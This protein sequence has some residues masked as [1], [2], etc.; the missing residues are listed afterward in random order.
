M[1]SI[2]IKIIL[3]CISAQ[4]INSSYAND[5]KSCKIYEH[6]DQK[7]HAV[8][9]NNFASLNNFDNYFIQRRSWHGHLFGWRG[10]DI[11][12]DKQASSISID[13][14]CTLSVWQFK[15]YIGEEQNYFNP[16]SSLAPFTRNLNLDALEDKISSATCFCG[17]YVTPIKRIEGK[18]NE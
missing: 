9:M 6:A 11:S 18:A 14:E 5:S 8:I 10:R 7:G 12:F 4:L 17:L 3:I 2:S 16:E 1:K 15:D 13:P